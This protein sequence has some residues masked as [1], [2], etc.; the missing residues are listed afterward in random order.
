MTIGTA[1]ILGASGKVGSHAA[2]AFETAGWTVRR[3][4]RG[5]DMTAAASGVDVIVNAMNPPSYHAW[6]RLV[7]QIT[8]EV[9][10][11]AHASGATVIIPGNVYNF[12]NRP[13]VWSEH[14]PHRP[15]A[16]K[17]KIR[18]EMEASYRASG[19]QTIILR[20][21]N[22][23]DPDRDDD[24]AGLV[25][26][27]GFK[28]GTITSPGGPDVMQPYCY[29]PDW[30]RAAEQL[31]RKRATLPAFVDVPFPGHPFTTRQFRDAL[32]RLTGRSLRIVGFPWWI[33]RVASPFWEFAR[34]MNEMR[35]LFETD[36]RLDDRLFNELL[37]DFEPTP[38]DTMLRS[39][40]PDAV[41]SSKAKATFA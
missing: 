24:A 38:Q 7:P 11:A 28:R 9:I 29:L 14:T 8:A 19:V 25:L 1:L 17:G 31:A 6:D 21:G 2:R 40:L 35:Y 32:Q 23:L 33:F 15:V 34:E 30:A 12:G 39:L 16:K 13:G 26:L 36:H 18:V 41:M 20:A 22:F 3:F 10:A 37:P 5:T 27:R 4:T